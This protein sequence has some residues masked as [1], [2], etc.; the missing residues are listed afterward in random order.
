[1]EDTSLFLENRFKLVSTSDEE[2]AVAFD[3]AP[4][5]TLRTRTSQNSSELEIV[6]LRLLY[7]KIRSLLSE[8]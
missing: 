1:M 7:R 3:K 2:H 6:K 5:K 4:P 8:L